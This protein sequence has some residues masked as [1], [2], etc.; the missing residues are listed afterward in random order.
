M[1]Q[2]Y[3]TLSNRT[4]STDEERFLRWPNDTE[5]E[6]IV[7]YIERNPVTAG[8]VGTPEESPWSSARPIDNRP[9][10]GNLPHISICHLP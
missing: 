9:Q 4:R 2:D 8:L 1:T 10:A 3:R 6:R 7:H 5:F